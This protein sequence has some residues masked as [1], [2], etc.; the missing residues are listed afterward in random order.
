[1]KELPELPPGQG[2]V[3]YILRV[4][5]GDTVVLLYQGQAERARLIGVDTPETKHPKKGVECFGPEASQFTS[6]TLPPGTEV[7]ITWNPLGKRRDK[8]NRLLVY[9]W[10][11]LDDDEPLE[12][13]N[14]A[15]VRLGY[16]R[17]YP[18]FPFDRLKEFRELEARAIAEKAG[19][20]G[21][22]NYAPLYKR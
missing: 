6:T 20:W 21:A 22:C 10:T 5:D 3:A 17:V 13:F 18:F 19:L 2:E 1:M 8:Y 9:I 11:Q 12:L 7:R 4:I 16:A 15:L 14:A